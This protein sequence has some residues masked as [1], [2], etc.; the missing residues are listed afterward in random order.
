MAIPARPKH[1]HQAVYNKLTGDAV[2][3]ALKVQLL[4]LCDRCD[5]E[6][7]NEATA[8]EKVFNDF[9]ASKHG[10]GAAI[11][12]KA[13][14]IVGHVKLLRPAAEYIAKKMSLDSSKVQDFFRWI[15]GLGSPSQVSDA[16]EWFAE[17][18]LSFIDSTGNSLLI[19]G[20]VCWLFREDISADAN[21][22]FNGSPGCLPCRLGLPSVLEKVPPYP[23]NLEFVG[24]CIGAAKLRN[25]RQATVFHGDYVSVRDIWLPGGR[26]QPIAAGPPGCVSMGGLLEF[27]ADAP[28]YN[29]IDA[30]IRVFST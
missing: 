16:R 4:T 10:S 5:H 15:A 19:S 18:L 7:G 22:A 30:N 11:T 26:T 17:D 23:K 24:I 25:P 1:M 27:V 2:P 13:G 12:L 29:Q 21:V 8:V 3:E 28:Y 14:E 6:I 9:A 20:P